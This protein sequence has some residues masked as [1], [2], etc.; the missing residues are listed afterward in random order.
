MNLFHAV[1]LGV[2]EGITEFLPISSTGHLILTVKLLGLTPPEFLKSFEIM[3]QLG[4]IL[5]VVALY[6]RPL[7]N[8]E[9]FKRV[10]TAFLPA[11][12][13]G[14]IFYKL[15]K[16]FLLGNPHVV[17]WALFAGG[18]FLIVFERF[19]REN[20]SSPGGLTD[21]PYSK[22][23]L[24]GLFQC[25]AMVPGVSRSGA[26]ILGGLALGLRRKIVVEFSFLLAVPTMLAAT[27]L[28]LVQNASSFSRNQIEFLLA[29]GITSFVVA[30][31]SIRF[32]LRFIRLHSFIPFG[33]YRIAVA[34]WF[35]LL[36]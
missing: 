12:A 7:F 5:A 27:A 6:W 9:I 24:V 14:F 18:L 10:L 3:I 22:C 4:A 23:F 31:L 25:L 36:L 15:I 20:K 28:D 32:L 30:I 29:G 34:L 13:A 8:L 11:A 21:I 19:H 35:W 26:T 1:V 33:V 16:R 2:V 17:L